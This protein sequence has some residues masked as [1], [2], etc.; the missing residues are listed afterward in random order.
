[1]KLR[2]VCLEF[3]F[4]A[5]LWFGQVLFSLQRETGVVPR[6]QD[7]KRVTKAVAKLEVESY[8][9]RILG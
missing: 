8:N 7:L 5:H 3:G 4:A 6:V 1:M 9:L 2:Q